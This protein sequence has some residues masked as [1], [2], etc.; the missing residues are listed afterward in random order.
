M[1]NNKKILIV[2]AHPDDEILGMGAS[3]AKFI[4]DNNQIFLLIMS[5]GVESRDYPRE[6]PEQRLEAA[7]SASRYLGVQELEILNFKDNQFDIHSELIINKTISEFVEN[8][9]P[10]YIF[11]HSA[12]DLNVD[13]QLVAKAC[14][15]ASRP[16]TDS[17]VK[18]VFSFEILSSTNWNFGNTLFEPNFFIDVSQYVDKKIEALKFYEAEMDSFPNSRSIL[19]VKALL[20]YRGT[21]V[22]SEAAEAFQILR[23]KS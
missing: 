12:C 9:Q 3:I 2:V 20:T 6:K 21:S 5:H 10:D 18:G 4:D 15:V 19:G 13:H 14:L 22:G 23:L 11:T 1:F 16:K 17:S 7:R 8:R